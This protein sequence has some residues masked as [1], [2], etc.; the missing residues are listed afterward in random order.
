MCFA[1][2]LLLYF[3]SSL[4]WFH[5]THNTTRVKMW[6]PKFN[7][8]RTY[9]YPVQGNNIKNRIPKVITL[10][11]LKVVEKYM[12]YLLSLNH[13]SKPQQRS[14]LDCSL[15]HYIYLIFCFVFLWPK[16]R[17]KKKKRK[18]DIEMLPYISNIHQWE[19]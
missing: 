11:T 7:L 17:K 10:I 5:H 8:L 19:T 3:L 12:I 1:Q 13:V 2:H 9:F 15:S 18:L 6:R 14:D 4:S 16:Q